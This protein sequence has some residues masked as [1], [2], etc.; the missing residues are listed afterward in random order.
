MHEVS[1]QL[2][3]ARPRKSVGFVL[4]FRRL[5]RLQSRRPEEGPE[6]GPGPDVLQPVD[7]Q[8][9][10]R[11]VDVVIVVVGVVIVGVVLRMKRYRPCSNNALKTQMPVLL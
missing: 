1:G 8:S 6:G 11:D 7:V 4:F 10:S 5:Q 3:D 2:H 9:C